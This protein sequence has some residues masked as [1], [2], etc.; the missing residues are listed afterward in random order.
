VEGDWRKLHNEEIMYMLHQNKGEMMDGACSSHGRHE[1][2]SQS[3]GQ[4][5]CMEETTLQDLGT[6]GKII[7]QWILGKY[8]GKVWTGCIWL[9]L[10]TSGGFL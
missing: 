3:F 8:G 2:C 1:K 7:L 5:T 6:D 10:G 9:R 4:K